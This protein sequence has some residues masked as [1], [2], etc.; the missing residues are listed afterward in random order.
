MLDRYFASTIRRPAI[1]GHSRSTL[2]MRAACGAVFGALMLLGAV[3]G[4]EPADETPE[5]QAPG[6]YW[7]QHLAP[8]FQASCQRCHGGA[9]QEGG[10]DL[11]TPRAS[12]KGARM[13]GSSEKRPTSLLWKVIQPDAENRM[14]PEGE[15]LTEDERLAVRRWL[16][17]GQANDW[18]HYAGD[19]DDQFVDPYALDEAS[20]PPADSDASAIIDQLLAESW[21]RDEIVP[22]D[23]ID[24]PQWVRRVY[25]DLLGRVP[26]VAERDAFLSNPDEAR[27]AQLVDQ[28]LSDPQ[29]ARY[30]AEILDTVFLGRSRRSRERREQGW[31]EFLERSV[32]DNRPWNEVVRAIV[33]ARPEQAT[34]R[35]AAWYLYE[36]GDKYQEIAESI[37]PAI[38]GVQIQCA[39]CH[40]HPLAS[41]IKQAHYWGLVAFF[42][43]GKPEM[44]PQGAQVAESAIGG[45]SNFADLEG[46]AQPNLLSYLGAEVV[47]EARPED[48]G[49]QQDADELYGPAVGIEGRTEGLPRVPLFSRREAFADQVVAG[50]P[51]VARAMVN[52]LWFMTMGRGLVHPVDK[53]DSTHPASHPELF[54]WLSRDFETHGYDIRR[55]LRALVL[56]DAY[57]RAAQRPTPSTPPDSFAYGLE[58]PLT[59][60][61]LGRSV[62]VV[63]AGDPDATAGQRGRML[64]EAFP[65]VFPE[66][67]ITT[68]SQTLFLT[69]HPDFNAWLGPEDGNLTSVLAGIENHDQ[70]ID[71]AF[72]RVLGRVASSEE[73]EA[74]R[75][76]LAARADRPQRAATDLVWALITSAEFRFN[77]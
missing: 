52:R 34:D 66:V 22:A 73:R 24:D 13:A 55:T 54:A 57:A 3:S 38:F 75:Q 67:T 53:L 12:C 2:I 21:Q 19:S 33:V 6:V 28:L 14:P 47:E 62:A 32:R 45:F 61:A 36:R 39:Q 30:F 8:L 25:L 40:D 68:L 31:I 17:S 70:Q 59:A 69:N 74:A 20:L 4:Q 41:E 43:R 23:L 44:T 50:H 16:E 60:E 9:K 77:H 37:S 64:A 56:S 51:W 48:P 15:P 26:T 65:E 42:N 5:A 49:S 1:L 11:R 76:F 63:L 29:H 27:R 10:V 7:E 71:V 46:N 72:Q 35:G 18:T 58:K